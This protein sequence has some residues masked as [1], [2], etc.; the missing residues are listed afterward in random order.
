MLIF[1]TRAVAKRLDMGAYPRLQEA[2][3]PIFKRL[4]SAFR[5][6]ILRHRWAAGFI[7][8]AAVLHD[9][10]SNSRWCIRGDPALTGT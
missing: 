8:V 4:A 6:S 5:A 1:K 3:L 9:S 10:V 7:G 2:G